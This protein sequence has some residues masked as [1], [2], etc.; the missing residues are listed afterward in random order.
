MASTIKW[1]AIKRVIEGRTFFLMSL[2][3]RQAVLLPRRAFPD[4]AAYADALAFARVHANAE[5][6]R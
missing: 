3:S 4:D 5:A 1:S 6:A 2:T